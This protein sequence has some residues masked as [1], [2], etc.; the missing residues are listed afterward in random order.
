MVILK[1]VHAKAFPWTIKNGIYMRGQVEYQGSIYTKDNAIEFFPILSTLK[2]PAE[3]SQL[4]K[5]LRG[6]FA[7]IIDFPEKE[8]TWCAVDIASSFPLFFHESK[9]LVSDDAELIRQT[10]NIAVNDISVAYCGELLLTGYNMF[11]HTAYAD[12]QQVDL[13]QCIYLQGTHCSKEFYYNH[14]STIIESSYEEAYERYKTVHRCM[15]DRMFRMLGNRQI[16]VALSGGYDSR[17]ILGLLKERGY[18]NVVCFT[19]GRKNK[20][21]IQFAEEICKKA[22]YPW[23]CIEY[24]DDLSR[25]MGSGYLDDY[26]YEAHHHSAL[27]HFSFYYPTKYLSENGLIDKDA[28]FVTGFCGDLPAGS[29]IFSNQDREQLR[30]N[31]DFLA[32]MFYYD[33]YFNYNCSKRTDETYISEIKDYLLSKFDFQ[34]DN[35]QSFVQMHDALF[36]VSRPGKFVVNANRAFDVLGYEW[37]LPLWDQDFLDFWYSVPYEY[38]TGQRLYRDFLNRELFDRWDISMLKHQAHSQPWY[39][40]RK[41]IP[42][43]FKHWAGSYLYRLS[44]YSN[45]PIKRRVD[46]DNQ[47]VTCLAY[48]QRIKT[49]SFVNFKRPTINPVMHV[50]LFENVYGPETLKQVKKFLNA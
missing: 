36:T 7:I 5:E 4:V 2:T 27:P 1:N 17:Y 47:G 10:A 26:F 42:T 22:G 35:F 24:T 45:I 12:I 3:F 23:Y 48:F 44:F 18:E 8:E 13:G 50:W 49:K 39:F 19:V 31:V 30:Y 25:A 34:P 20:F 41:R 21:E 38:R 43:K 29:F 37:L 40:R 33:E 15:A 14:T 9:H 32:E 6:N 16:V 28:V 46:V 11:N